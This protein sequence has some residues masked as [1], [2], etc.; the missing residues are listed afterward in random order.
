MTEEMC[1][2]G[3]NEFWYWTVKSAECLQRDQ[4]ER[5]IAIGGILNEH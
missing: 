3:L 1:T 5:Y 4:N 2:A